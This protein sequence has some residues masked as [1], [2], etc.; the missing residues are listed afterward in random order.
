MLLHPGVIVLYRLYHNG[1]LVHSSSSACNLTLTEL[2]TWSA[3]EFRLETCTAVGCT[4]SPSVLSRTQELPPEGLI[5]LAVN[6]SSAR[7]VLLYWTPV[8]AANGLLRYDVYFSGP[9]YTQGKVRRLT[10]AE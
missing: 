10:A 8:S 7:S 6:V 2:E 5:G 3:H 4:S 1:I 9:F